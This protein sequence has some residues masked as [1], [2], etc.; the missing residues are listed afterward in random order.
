MF[1]VCFRLFLNVFS[2]VDV[3]FSD[4]GAARL[5]SEY[6]SFENSLFVC[7]YSRYFMPVFDLHCFSFRLTSCLLLGALRM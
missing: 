5:F 6:V 4:V 1:F 7:L 3:Q 2:L